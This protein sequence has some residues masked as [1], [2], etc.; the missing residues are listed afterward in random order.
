LTAQPQYEACAYVIYFDFFAF[1]FFLAMMMFLGVSDE[2]TAGLV[3]SGDLR[4]RSLGLSPLT[5]ND[6]ATARLRA[7]SKNRKKPLF[8]RSLTVVQVAINQRSAR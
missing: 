2:P 7:Q 8:F 4:S 1:F 5:E 6:S 3:Q